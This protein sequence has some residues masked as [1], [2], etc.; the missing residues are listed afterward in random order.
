MTTNNKT[1]SF[2][3]KQSANGTGTDGLH[4]ASSW[5]NKGYTALKNGLLNISIEEN[6]VTYTFDGK[7]YPVD[8]LLAAE[9]ALYE[10]LQGKDTDVVEQLTLAAAGF[11]NKQQSNFAKRESD[12]KLN[13]VIRTTKV[14]TAMQ[15][16]EHCIKSA[17]LDKV[18][19]YHDLTGLLAD[20]KVTREKLLN[21]VST[22]VD[23]LLTD[24]QAGT[25]ANMVAEEE[26]AAKQ[27]EA[28]LAAGFTDISRTDETIVASLATA[29]AVAI[30][31]LPALGYELVNSSFDAA[32]LTV[33]V[34]FKEI[35]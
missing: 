11:L 19:L 1:A 29:N 28:L 12:S 13:P 30:Q 31:Q 23:L 3:T 18:A 22:L 10:G 21:Y 14:L 32:T 9:K 5:L 24:E 27:Y 6:V 16:R 17:D 7:D 2:F 25:Y 8:I 26:T 15:Y 35:K 4:A 20:S 34:E 33:T